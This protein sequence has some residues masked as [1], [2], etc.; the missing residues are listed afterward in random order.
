MLIKCG[1][2]WEK[3]VITPNINL[4]CN[5]NIEHNIIYIYIYIY[6]YIK[7]LV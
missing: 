5:S 4:G 7:L 2:S 1:S 6:I 3:N